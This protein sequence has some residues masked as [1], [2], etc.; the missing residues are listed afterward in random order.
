MRAS[1]SSSSFETKVVKAWGLTW[2]SCLCVLMGSWLLGRQVLGT[3]HA[4]SNISVQV[5]NLRQCSDP[6]LESF[7]CL[8]FLVAPLPHGAMGIFLGS[9]PLPVPQGNRELGCLRQA[10]HPSCRHPPGF[11]PCE[12]WPLSCPPQAA[13]ACPCPGQ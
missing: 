1:C 5:P 6:L 12:M 11:L 13:S 7:F 10:K 8:F 3:R 4:L 2:L 9:S